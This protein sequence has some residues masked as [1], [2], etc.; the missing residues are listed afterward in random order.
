MLNLNNLRFK[1]KLGILVSVFTLGI[2][3]FVPV[4]ITTINTVKV[5]GPL[6]SKIVQG[7]DLIADILPPPEYL[8]ETYLVTLQMVD[9]TNPKK[10]SSLLEKGKS[11]RNDFETRHKYWQNDLPDGGMKE[12]LIK[13]SYQPAMDFYQMWDDEFVP[14]LQKGDRSKAVSLIQ[15]EYAGDHAKIKNALNRAVQNLETTLIQ[16]RI[17]AE[18]VSEA[19]Q[20][21]SNGSQSLSHGAS[22]QAA[23]LE[24]TSSSLHELSTMTQQNTEHANE[25]RILAEKA[26]S[27]AQ[28]SEY[29]IHELNDSIDAI[30]VSADSTAKVVKIINEIA[31]QTNLLALNSAVEAARAGDAG[32]GFAVVAAEVR[33]LAIRS[34]EAA[35]D[36]ANLIADSIKNVESG[37]R[38]NQKM[39]VELQALNDQVTKI[40]A[41]ITEISSASKQ[42]KEGM[43]QI[44]KAIDQIS[45]VTQQTAAN[46]EEAAS[47]SE[48]LTGQSGEMMS[49]IGTF[50]LR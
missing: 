1:W 29:V 15:G 27:S 45:Q 13:D 37:F 3:V 17:G 50:T 16:A 6:Y 18:Q 11:L 7:K 38:T 21:I 31:F 34:A 12:A 47:A 42:Q 30:K 36:T 32:K 14:A 44:S 35:H 48:E 28:K 33:N 4:A 26:K 41:V 39:V 22:E 46:A 49:L 10:F 23:S 5:N 40:H 24:E 43:Q 19:A 9:E 2:I 25:A 8:L 20:Q